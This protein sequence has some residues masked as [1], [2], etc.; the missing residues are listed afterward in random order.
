[1]ANSYIILCQKKN[2]RGDFICDGELHQIRIAACFEYWK[3][4]KCGTL[5]QFT[6]DALAYHK[7]NA[8]KK[9]PP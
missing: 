9:V 1:M 3:C 4:N 7:K 8:Q 2:S 5:H 6:P